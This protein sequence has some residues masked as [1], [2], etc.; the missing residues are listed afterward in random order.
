MIGVWE[1]PSSQSN[2]GSFPDL[3]KCHLFSFRREIAMKRLS[4]PWRSRCCCFAPSLL[5]PLLMN[6]R[7]QY[8]CLPLCRLL[9]QNHRSNPFQVSL[10]CIQIP[11]FFLRGWSYC[12][13]YISR[14]KRVEWQ[15]FWSPVLLWRL[16]QNC[17][18][19]SPPASLVK[20]V[21]AW[22][23]IFHIEMRLVSRIFESCQ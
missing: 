11:T 7:P 23:L 6:R 17:F 18:F 14:E 8:C 10:L 16:F 12:Y 1:N 3:S 9:S 15:K 20:K 21:V 2:V 22:G 4:K 19:P 13:Y 5:L